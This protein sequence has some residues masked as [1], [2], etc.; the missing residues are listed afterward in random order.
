[1]NSTFYSDGDQD[2]LDNNPD[3]SIASRKNEKGQETNIYTIEYYQ[4]YVDAQRNIN[5]VLA[6]M[7]NKI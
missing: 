4:G 5:R 6:I 2:R 3:C 7:A 1:M